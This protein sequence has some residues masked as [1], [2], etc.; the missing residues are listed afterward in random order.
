MAL[1]RDLQKSV[2]ANSDRQGIAEHASASHTVDA[3][4]SA[5]IRQLDTTR[6]RAPRRRGPRTAAGKARVAS[7]ALK[8]GI[9]SIRPVVPGESN[10]KW[11]THRRA[12]VEDLAPEGPVETALAERVASAVWRLRRVTAYE[13]AAI[14]ERENLPIASARLLPHPNAINMVIR[15]EAH[16]TRQL[17]QALH[18]LEAMRAER[19]GRAMP[20]VRV[21]AQGP[22]EALAPTGATIVGVHARP[23][24]PHSE[25]TQAAH[26]RISET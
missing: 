19:R 5:E 17:Y 7:N 12:F 10:D 6:P 16:L 14:A 1:D 9:S 4:T 26:H 3:S 24:T 21:D 25:M 15:Y 22:T 2:A 13:E 8:H 11:E 20:L 18:E 23:A